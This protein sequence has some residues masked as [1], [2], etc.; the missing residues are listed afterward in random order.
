MAAI[1]GKGRARFAGMT[2]PF[3]IAERCQS[4][5]MGRSRKPLSPNRVPRVR[6]PVSPPLNSQE[7]FL[8]YLAELEDVASA[9]VRKYAGR[10]YRVV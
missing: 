7:K 6:I 3:R 2:L 5:R 10:I 1:F 4:G 9:D 8:E